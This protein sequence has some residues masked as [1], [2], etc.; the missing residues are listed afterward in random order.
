VDALN[1]LVN[2]SLV[3]QRE[4]GGG[5]R[6]T[7]LETVRAYALERVAECGETQMV[8][9]RHAEYYLAL[10]EEADPHPRT[11][12]QPVWLDRLEVER[13]HTRAAL[14][15]FLEH[16]AD[17]ERGLRLAGALRWFRIMH[18]Q[19]SEGRGW[20]NRALQGG[21]AFLAGRSHPYTLTR[22]REHCHKRTHASFIKINVI[23]I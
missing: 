11:G 8:W 9:Q 19:A 23:L 13:S 20:S 2:N 10:A 7:L 1:S 12:E 3:V 14:T 22:A 5:P 17:Q 16:T 4:Q 18:G 21:Y 6:F 15:W